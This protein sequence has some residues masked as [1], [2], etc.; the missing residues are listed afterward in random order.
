MRSRREFVHRHAPTGPSLLLIV[1]LLFAFW[2]AVGVG[3]AAAF[4]AL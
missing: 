3:T 1:L 2:A 4:G